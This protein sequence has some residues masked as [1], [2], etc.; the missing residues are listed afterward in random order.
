VISEKK[1]KQLLCF[2]HNYHSKVWG[3]EVNAFTQQGHIKLIKVS[4]KTFKMS[5][6]I[7]FQI[8]AAFDLSINKRILKKMYQT[9]RKLSSTTAFNIDNNTY[10]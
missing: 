6:K 3:Q 8:N 5:Q 7:L 4:E 9:S 10:F 2:V 1:K